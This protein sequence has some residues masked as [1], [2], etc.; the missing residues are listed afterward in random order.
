MYVCVYVCMLENVSELWFAENIKL[1]PAGV[2]ARTEN[3]SGYTA[4]TRI[5][6]Q[7]KRH[8]RRQRQWQRQRR[9]QQWFTHTQHYHSVN[10]DNGNGDGDDDDDDYHYYYVSYYICVGK[11]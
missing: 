2:K 1:S 11:E 7:R 6:W 5:Q 3:N 9:R 8:R 4:A 10:D